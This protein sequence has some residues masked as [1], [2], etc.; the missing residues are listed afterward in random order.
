MTRSARLTIG[1]L[2]ALYLL[3]L[4]T[5]LVLGDGPYGPKTYYWDQAVP[6]AATGIIALIAARRRS[7]PYRWFLVL[8]GLAFL[9]LAAAWVTYQ[10]SSGSTGVALSPQE[11]GRAA[12]DFVSDWIYA[13]CV[14]VLMCAWGYLALERWSSRPL[15]ALTSL[16]FAALIAGLGA[17][18]AS[19]YYQQYGQALNTVFGRL[20]AV[21]AAIEFA[22]LAIGLLCM[23]LKEPPAVVWTLVG[24]VV[25]MAGDMAY[26]VAE[27]PDVIEAV[28]M[29]GQF[30][31]L[32][33][34]L[35]SA[36][37]ASMRR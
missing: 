10:T 15:S 22:V 18:F 25:L 24:T 35:G 2:V 11:A 14:F 7:A 29:V 17:I 23:L 8:Q 16:V 31:V 3:W 9:L 36:G 5:W 27:V 37:G 20:D 6:A 12:A 1:A 30:L 33:A 34:V 4:T 19:F 28:W 26:S 21:T 32:A 13:G